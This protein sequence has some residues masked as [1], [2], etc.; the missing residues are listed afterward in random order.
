MKF[1]RTLLPLRGQYDLAPFLCV[2][3]LLLFFLFLGGHLVLPAGTRIELP[4][5]ETHA[6]QWDGAPFL[7]VAVDANEQCYFENQ[8]VPD[9]GTLQ[10]RLALRASAP[11][12]PRRLYLEADH[13]VRYGKITELGAL[14]RA[15]GITEI[16]L[17]GS[18]TAPK[19]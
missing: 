10:A 4:P 14:A 8:V 19:P 5:T 11:R 2:L 6:T 18:P 1:Q 15:A 12:G 7:V 17:E 16:L 13:R 9:P 3:F